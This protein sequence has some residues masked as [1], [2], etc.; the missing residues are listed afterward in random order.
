[1]EP[2]RETI[3]ASAIV[4]EEQQ[5]AVAGAEPCTMPAEQELTA[6]ATVVEP[7]V[8]ADNG[9]IHGIDLMLLPTEALR[10]F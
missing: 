4:D 6:V 10:S 1:V 2:K 7:D 5:D 3:P 9:V 8:E